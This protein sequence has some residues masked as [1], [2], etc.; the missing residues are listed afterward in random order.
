MRSSLR[1]IP[2]QL[3]PSTPFLSTREIVAWFALN[4]A[5]VCQFLEFQRDGSSARFD[6]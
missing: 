4:K 2:L 6:F 1:K 5:L 3:R